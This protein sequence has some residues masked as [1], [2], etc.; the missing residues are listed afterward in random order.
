MVNGIGPK[1]YVRY[2]SWLIPTCFLTGT[3]KEIVNNI[4]PYIDRDKYYLD[5]KNKIE[6]ERSKQEDSK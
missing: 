4:K 2:D 1:T 6:L 3:K 5:T